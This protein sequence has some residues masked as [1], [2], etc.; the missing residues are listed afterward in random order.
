MAKAH[1]ISDNDILEIKKLYISGLSYVDIAKAFGV[2]SKTIEYHMKDSDVYKIKKEQEEKE[3]NEIISL[4][5]LNVPLKEISRRFN[6]TKWTICNRLKRW[7]ISL[8]GKNRKYIPSRFNIPVEEI[9]KKYEEFGDANLTAK[10]FGVSRPTINSFLK[11]NNIK[12]IK[13]RKSELIE[14]DKDIIKYLYYDKFISLEEIAE[15]YNSCCSWISEKF[16][17]WG[18]KARD[19]TYSDTSLERSVEKILQ[20]LN[21]EYQKQFKIDKK[22]YDFYISNNNLLI[23]C[24]GDYW[25][26]NPKIYNKFDDR[27]TKIKL[28]DEFKKQLAKNSGYNLIELWEYDVNNH[29]NEVISKIKNNL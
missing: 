6:I 18:W 25:H 14:R 17:Q 20:D 23:E 7:G 16:R 8:K 13:Y 9:I 28:N 22:L 24:H 27:Q 4:Y 10:Y 15:E 29:I 5:N 1:L 11:K 2:S 3:K 26:G 21:L 12:Q 19:A